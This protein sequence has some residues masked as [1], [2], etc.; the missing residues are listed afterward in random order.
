MYNSNQIIVD[1]VY[2]ARR[3]NISLRQAFNEDR[4]FRNRIVGNIQ[5][6]MF[7]NNTDNLPENVSSSP[8]ETD[9]ELLARF[10]SLGADSDS[11][12]ALIEA[13]IFALENIL[14][15]SPNIEP[16]D[17]NLLV[18]DSSNLESN[19]VTDLMSSEINESASSVLYSEPRVLPKLFNVTGSGDVASNMRHL[20]EYT[21]ELMKQNQLRQS[22][23]ATDLAESKKLVN[24]AE[25]IEDNRRI[26]NT[27]SELKQL[28]E[29]DR[30]SSLNDLFGKYKT[31]LLLSS[32]SVVGVALSYKFLNAGILETLLFSGYSESP[33]DA[34]SITSSSQLVMPQI[35]LNVYGS[36]TSINFINGSSNES[37]SVHS[38]SVESIL[39][40]ASSRANA[41]VSD[42][43]LEDTTTASNFL[44]AATL[45]TTFTALVRKSIT[46]IN[47]IRLIFSRKKK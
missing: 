18:N 38:S 5:A 20:V 14:D 31:I 25:S 34:S 47:S 9:Q 26:D 1:T 37:S 16:V 36:N 23:I 19:I 30:I 39:D 3:N 21:S 10:D 42:S 46:N 28:T 27:L 45:F 43:I 44:L 11:R 24:D 13:G 6:S 2:N 12:S 15:I 29:I 40:I 35:Q 32:M 17:M 33:S 7:E 4:E 22:E 8:L 41:T